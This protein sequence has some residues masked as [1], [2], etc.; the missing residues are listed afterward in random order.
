MHSAERAV[1]M[2]A[3]CQHGVVSLS[4]ARAKGMTVDQIKRRVRSGR[5]RRVLPSV[6]AM[7][8]APETW[9]KQLRAAALW[10]PRATF[11][12]R[13]AAALWGLARFT[14]ETSPITLSSTI[15]T[16]AP[17]GL[18]F[19]RRKLLLPREV[20]L[21][22]GLKVTSVER[23]LL[24]LCL[25]EAEPDVAAAL[26]DALRKKLTT[27]ERLES[28]LSRRAGEP[29]S[30]LLRRLVARR[31]GDEGIPES[32]LES[33]VLTFLDEHGF[34]APARQTRVRVRGRR[35]RLDFT[36]AEAPVVIEADGYAWHSTV[37]SFEA[38]RRR[39]N[40]LTA[41]GYRVLQW[42]WA[43]LDERPGELVHELRT[44]LATSSSSAARASR[45]AT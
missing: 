29:G 22:Q 40:A 41:R 10:A 21:T 35:F 20:G 11:S 13:T 45:G 39:I 25:D 36:F 27:T 8:G 9:M 6:Y 18:R 32:E 17:P 4:Q 15:H 42:T 1:V 38:D 33:R 43:A 7:E 14:D 24:D 31:T 3:S 26:D 37:A 16:P 19:V 28:L 30:G 23:T 12:H 2:V 34:P 44:L 5:W